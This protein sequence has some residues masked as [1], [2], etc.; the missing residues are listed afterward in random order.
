MENGPPITIP[1]TTG[2][3]WLQ[4]V[5]SGPFFWSM[6]DFL[7]RWD[8]RSDQRWFFSPKHCKLRISQTTCSIPVRLQIG[9][10]CSRQHFKE[11]S[12]LGWYHD[13]IAKDSRMLI[14]K[15]LDDG[16]CLYN[17][18]ILRFLPGRFWSDIQYMS[19]YCYILL[20]FV[21][22]TWRSTKSRVTNEQAQVDVG[23]KHLFCTIYY[24]F[25][26][27]TCFLKS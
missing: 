11:L 22:P 18:Q 10:Q 15:F 17:I 26:L 14:L 9:N 24:S 2:M 1:D 25:F 7:L 8:T 23:I 19:G 21:L 5:H 4:S 16:G 3:L 12:I 20:N 27:S 6:G 13:N